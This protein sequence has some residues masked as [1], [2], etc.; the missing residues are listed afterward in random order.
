MTRGI[1]VLPVLGEFGCYV[2]SFV[3]AVHGLIK[4]H[5]RVVVCCRKGEGWLFPGAA[6]FIHEYDPDF[7]PDY[8][9]VG[10]YAQGRIDFSRQVQAYLRALSA[11]LRLQF[12]DEYDVVQLDF[13]GFDRALKQHN[14]RIRAP[15]AVELPELPYVCLGP[16][17]RGFAGSRNLPYDVWLAIL[18]SVSQ[19]GMGAA[20]I[21]VADTS[22]HFDHPAVVATTYQAPPAAV[23][24]Q[25]AA[26]IAGSRAFIGS[27]SG[28]AHLADV[29][30]K[31]LYLVSN[32]LD[33]VAGF[34]LHGRSDSRLVPQHEAA[35]GL[36]AYLT[37]I[38]SGPTSPGSAERAG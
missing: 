3:R 25:S 6:G 5:E 16:R 30:R 20:L 36:A 24:A 18:D 34:L 23:T 33:V 28:T 4:T 32:G 12:G 26:L 11:Q 8:A 7:L 10:Y 35:A 21:G 17:C 1:I 31:P 22:Y 15:G 29:L 2:G 9:R 37:E 27:D 19:V 14:P 13:R 38:G